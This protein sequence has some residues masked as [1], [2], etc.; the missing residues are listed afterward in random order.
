MAQVHFHIEQ[1][2]EE[3]GYL[4][5]ETSTME[6]RV[7]T[8]VSPQET[9]S[10]LEHG[11]RRFGYQYFRP[12]CAGCS[13]CVSLRVPVAGFRPSKSQRRVL[14][15]CSHLRVEVRT[16][17]ADHVR[18]ELH[19]AWH[20]VRERSR[21]WKPGAQ[22]LEEYAETF[23]IPHP[24]AREIDYYDGS[25]LVA[26]GLVDETPDALSSIYFFHDPQ[27]SHLSLGTASV[28]FEIDWVRSRGGSHLY[29]GFCVAACPSTAYK[30]RFGPHERLV[31]RPGLEDEAIWRP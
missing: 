22:T 2:A 24:C 14:R 4:P 10:L 19:Q 17:K 30:A 1:S 16:P 3:C 18:F 31:G 21:G 8:G 12:V 11:W 7:M 6:Y 13:Q 23:C 26:V 28:L 9:Q 27:W 5:G 15:Q 20:A 29:M 25:R